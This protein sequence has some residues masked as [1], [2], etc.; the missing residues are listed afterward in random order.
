MPAHTSCLKQ[1]IPEMLQLRKK[2]FLCD[3]KEAK[4]CIATKYVKHDLIVKL[5]SNFR[6]NSTIIHNRGHSL[7]AMVS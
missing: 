2:K 5:L 3:I 7:V 1:A 6:S 4:F